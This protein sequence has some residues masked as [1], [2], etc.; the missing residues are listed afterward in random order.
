MEANGHELRHLRGRGKAADELL[1]S[2]LRSLIQ[3]SWERSSLHP[4][5]RLTVQVRTTLPKGALPDA[6]L[7]RVGTTLDSSLL[8]LFAGAQSTAD[9][10]LHFDAGEFTCHLEF[11]AGSIVVASTTEVGHDPASGKAQVVDQ[12]ESQGQELRDKVRAALR[13]LLPAK[14]QPPEARMAALG[15]LQSALVN[16]LATDLQEPLQSMIEQMPAD[17]RAEK[18]AI[19]T[20]VNGT[21][22]RLGMAIRCPK[23][24]R[25][26]LLV[27]DQKQADSDISRF[28]LEI[29]DEAGKKT[30]TFSSTTLPTLELRQDEPRSEPLVEWTQRIKKS[31]QKTERG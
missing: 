15:A 8:P 23:T 29:R 7:E 10:R 20:F 4:A 9:W 18:Q 24:G 17:T 2:D 1:H 31:D 19:C 28:R 26:A 27:A 5:G 14:Q 30:R 25:P 12:P 13:K 11:A 3:A 22:R 21:L 6:V 16:E